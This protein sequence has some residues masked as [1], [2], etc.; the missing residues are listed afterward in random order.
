MP[1]TN[2]WPE[3]KLYVKETLGGLVKDMKD[4][5]ESVVLVRESVAG[6]K[7]WVSVW[8]GILGAA[9]GAAINLALK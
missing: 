6:L 2:G 1:K 5:R 9:A 7:V 4:L 3:H 8:G